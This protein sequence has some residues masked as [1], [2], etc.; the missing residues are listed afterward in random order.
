MER[1][2]NL[3]DN[4]PRAAASCI[5]RMQKALTQMNVQL[6]NV[7]AIYRVN[8]DGTGLQVITH[9]SPVL[10]EWEANYSPDGKTI[11]FGAKW[12]NLPFPDTFMKPALAGC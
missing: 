8:I 4:E 2:L 7:C 11:S 1:F 10:N 9:F 12:Q 3:I 6:A 5:Q